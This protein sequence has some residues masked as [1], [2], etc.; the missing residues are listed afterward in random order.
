VFIVLFLALGLYIFV[1]WVNDRLQINAEHKRFVAMDNQLASL[2]GQIAKVSNPQI[3]SSHDCSYTSTGAVFGPKFLSCG[4]RVK[5]VYGG[6][7]K[8]QAEELTKQLTG[9]LV[10]DGIQLVRN[11]NAVVEHDLA[12]YVFDSHKVSCAFSS[13]Y[14]DNNVPPQDRY[15]GAPDEGTAAFLEIDCSGEAKAEYFSVTTN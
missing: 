12:V 4:S 1:A 8:D 14:Y 11:D 6:V 5:V 15:D 9:M 2:A 7:A 10:Q 3:N 13:T